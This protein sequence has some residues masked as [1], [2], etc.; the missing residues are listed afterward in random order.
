MLEYKD[1]KWKA[2]LAL[3]PTLILMIVFTFYPIFNT[4]LNAFMEGY[5]YGV[6]RDTASAIGWLDHFGET[7]MQ[8]NYNGNGELIGFTKEHKLWLTNDD[9]QTAISK[10]MVESFIF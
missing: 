7:V 4:I 8:S 5:T 1:D 3:A 2:L 10:G 6:W 9:P